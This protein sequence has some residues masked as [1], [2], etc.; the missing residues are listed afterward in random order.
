MSRLRIFGLDFDS[1]LDSVPDFELDFALV[2][3]LES[4]PVRFG[5]LKAQ[6]HFVN[7]VAET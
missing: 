1:A 7:F 2:L 6:L 5:Y 4:V 3:P